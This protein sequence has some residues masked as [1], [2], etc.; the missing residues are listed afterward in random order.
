ML[1]KQN[2]EGKLVPSELK[3]EKRFRESIRSVSDLATG[4]HATQVNTAVSF[5]FA[6]K[7]LPMR[8]SN[9]SVSIW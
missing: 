2:D 6:F 4:D 7:P 9:I 8:V 5:N 1:N 3:A